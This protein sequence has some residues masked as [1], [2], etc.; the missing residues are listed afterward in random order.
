MEDTALRV[1]TEVLQG[2]HLEQTREVDKEYLINN[3]NY[4][5]FQEDTA[6]ARFRHKRYTRTFTVEV[7][8]EPCF[9]DTLSVAWIE[10]PA[11]SEQLDLFEL[12]DIILRD[13]GNILI[14]P[15][16]D[17]KI[18][19]AGFTIPLPE[20]VSCAS[21]RASNRSQAAGVEATVL[22]NGSVFK[23]TLIDFSAAAFKI[24][25]SAVPPATFRWLNTEAPVIVSLVQENR[26]YFSGECRVLR[27]EGNDHKKT[28]VFAPVQSKVQRFKAKEFRGKRYTPPSPLYASFTHP[29]SE[30]TW[31]L[32]ISDISGSGF[33]IP[34]HEYHSKLIPGL[35]I[36][37]V[38]IVLPG[39]TRLPCTA[40]VIYKRESMQR[41][42][43]KEVISGFA[44]LDMNPEHH[45]R[46]LCFLHQE[47]DSNSFLCMN[48]DMHEL[49]H[50]FF[51]SGFIYPEKYAY[52]LENKEEI[53]ATYRRLYTESPGIAR[54]F[55]YQQDGC[56]L[57]HMSMLRS[58]ENA[59][60]LH[61]H[62]S[63]KHKSH[64]AGLH[65]LNQVGSFGNN[66]HRI[67]SMHM[68]YLL[69]YFRPE[70][71]FPKKVFG[72]IAEK[73]GDPGVCS[74]DKYAF[75]HLTEG[76]T[77][78][79]PA[80]DDS[81]S[82]ERTTS[83]DM[84]DLKSYYEQVSGGLMLKSYNL[85]DETGESDTLYDAYTET[86]FFRSISLFSIKQDQN[87]KAV[88]MVDRS[89]AGLNMSDL[90]NSIK[91]F[92]TDQEH[93]SREILFY[94]LRMV[95]RDFTGSSPSVLLFPEQ[96]MADNEIGYEKTYTLWVINM[97]E[98][99]RYFEHLK[100]L[101][102]FTQY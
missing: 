77:G 95:S 21:D 82:L 4:T 62:A 29:F 67:H 91:V 23:G 22:Q 11:Q 73:I 88:I 25:L 101:L 80:D 56:I 94:C 15:A 89:D 48:V 13:N 28:C 66:S 57:G 42:R 76:L 39:G 52:M 63:S 34:E 58:Y 20:R 31:E 74:L 92:I 53:K 27:T 6:L 18:D 69:C 85:D 36:P 50:F 2:A 5:N 12:Q 46:L 99:D 96:Y 70:N 45:T 30:K 8:P 59:W 72:E 1:N 98:S 44:I 60:L 19:E 40:Q 26:M 41:G 90:I 3:V 79:P 54:H 71:R 16:V 78:H 32:P 43:D 51:D 10:D 97:E 93:L 35:I 65:V 38:N 86:G 100:K 64:N 84:K 7:K 68:D 37:E 24:D 55:I 9:G 87:L 75:F 33:S 17:P 83:R 81:W 102:R 47:N 49:W 14:I 61:H